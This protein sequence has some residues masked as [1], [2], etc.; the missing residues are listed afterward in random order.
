MPDEGSL[1]VPPAPPLN[2]KREEVGAVMASIATGLKPRVALRAAGFP[3]AMVRQIV[4]HEGFRAMAEEAR[5]KFVQG[6][7]KAIV[8]AEAKDWKAAAWMLE[9][10]LPEE[11]GRKDKVEQTVKIEALPWRSSLDGAVID[12]KVVEVKPVEGGNGEGGQE[13]P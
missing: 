4:K 11:Y 2:M 9:R 5:A 3:E 6:R 1:P 7:V 8:D 10:V 12:A 13:A